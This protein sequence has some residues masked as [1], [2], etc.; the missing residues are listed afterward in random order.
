MACVTSS[1]MLHSKSRGAEW[2]WGSRRVSSAPGCFTALVTHQA[3]Y[4]ATPSSRTLSDLARRMSFQLD[5]TSDAMFKAEVTDV[6]GTLQGLLSAVPIGACSH[7]MADCYWHDMCDSNV[8][9]GLVV[10]S[11]VIEVYQGWC[12]PCKAIQSTFKKLFFD[13][14]DR[15]IKFYTVRARAGCRVATGDI[16]VRSGLRSTSL[17]LLRALSCRFARKR[18]RS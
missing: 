1:F 4:R 9:H 8:A 2:L 10:T 13:L 16:Q 12:G 5:I 18:C 17:T 6:P 7:L 11:A 3:H 15:P 14:N